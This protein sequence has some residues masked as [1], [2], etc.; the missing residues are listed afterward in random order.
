MSTA[1]NKT[2]KPAVT[3]PATAD[4]TKGASL[5]ELS[6]GYLRKKSHYDGQVGNLTKR[7]ESGRANLERIQATVTG[8]QEKLAT[9]EAPSMARELADPLAKELLKLLPGYESYKVAGPV[10]DGEAVILTFF[11]K[12]VTPEEQEKG[13]KSKSVTLITKLGDG[14]LGVRDYTKNTNQHK[15]GTIGYLNGENHPTVKVPEGAKAGWLISWVK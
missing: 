3:A 4:T 7:I 14:G 10:G 9:L 12:G 13:L 1:K 8:C 2:E 5:E 6:S 11:E 15:P